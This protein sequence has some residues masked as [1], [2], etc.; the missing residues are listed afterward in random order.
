MFPS[1][2]AVLTRWMAMLVGPK[3]VHRWLASLPSCRAA[4][5]ASLM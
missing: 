5:L 1:S 3:A 4:L 2:T